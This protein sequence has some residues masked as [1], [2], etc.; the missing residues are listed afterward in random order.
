MLWARI[1]VLLLLIIMMKGERKK[2]GGIKD[3]G[4]GKIKLNSFCLYPT[5]VVRIYTKKSPRLA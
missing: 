4:R 2:E 5:L 1:N 3:M